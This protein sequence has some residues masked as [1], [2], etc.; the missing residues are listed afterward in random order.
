VSAFTMDNLAF[1][2]TAGQS[3][4]NSG[5]KFMLSVEDAQKFCS[6]DRSKGSLYGSEWAYFYTTVREFIYRGKP[7]EKKKNPNLL[8]VSRV[9][10]NGS[11]DPLLKE[12]GCKKIP[13]QDFHIYLE[14]LGVQVKGKIRSK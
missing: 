10:D 2:Y 9:F 4:K 3:G 14:P 1:L 11:F 6:D 13:V 8:D 12:L 5:I 7:P